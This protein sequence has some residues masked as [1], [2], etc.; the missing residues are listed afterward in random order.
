MDGVTWWIYHLGKTKIKAEDF[1]SSLLELCWLNSKTACTGSSREGRVIAHANLGKGCYSP[2]FYFFPPPNNTQ[3]EDHQ[4]LSLTP[5][6]CLGGHASIRSARRGRPGVCEV[7]PAVSPVGG[8]ARPGKGQGG[9][10]GRWG[11]SSV[12]LPGSAAAWLPGRVL[13]QAGR[14]TVPPMG[15]AAGLRCRTSVQVRRERGSARRGTSVRECCHLPAPQPGSGGGP[16]VCLCRYPPGPV[17][18]PSPRGVTRGAK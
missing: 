13:A 9:R 18:D 7:I 17:L 12:S 5:S 3:D 2:F 10:A 4:V 6:Q 14:D 8:H 1:L 16:A 11:S 15:I